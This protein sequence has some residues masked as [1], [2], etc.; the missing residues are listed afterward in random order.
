MIKLK[1]INSFSIIKSKTNSLFNLSK[2]KL[3]SEKKVK[4]NTPVELRILTPNSISIKNRTFF[5]LNKTDKKS[6]SK[7]SLTPTKKITI[8][9]I[10]NEKTEKRPKSRFGISPLKKFQKRNSQ[11]FVKYVQDYPKTFY[12][13]IYNNIEKMKIK[14]DR[15]IKVMRRNLRLTN[16]D[17]FLRATNLVNINTLINR[18]LKLKKESLKKKENKKNNTN[19]EQELSEEQNKK[20]EDYIDSNSKN[21]QY[22][23]RKIDNSLS[24]KKNLGLE[25]ISLK[26]F[27]NIKLK[28]F[29]IPLFK[30]LE[31]NNKYYKNMYHTRFSEMKDSTNTNE[32]SKKIYDAPY[33]LQKVNIFLKQPEVQL[34]SIYNKLK[35]LLN[36]IQYFYN[37]FLIKREFRHAFINMENPVKAHFNMIIEEVCIL[38]VKL[39][40]LILKEFYFSLS[41]LLFINIPQ[42]NEEME[43]TP[44]NEI[45]CLKYNIHFFQKVKDYYSA[46]VD[47]YNVIQKQIAEFKF[48]PNEFTALNNILDLARYNSTNLIS[49]A[50]TQIEKTKNDDDI[51]N[52]FEIGLNIKKKK[53][54]EKESGFERFH[55]RRKMKLLDDKEKINRIKSALNIGTKDLHNQFIVKLNNKENENQSILNSYLIKDMMNYFTP[56]IKQ[57]IISQQ[58]IERFKKLELERLKFD[59]DNR[60]MNDGSSINIEE[61]EN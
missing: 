57:K 49:M 58:V 15:T 4:F 3:K 10:E 34:K 8:K 30:S 25:K 19:I 29:Y 47:I 60:R 35:L 17:V 28:P 26:P 36:N 22:N 38:V 24:E 31:N 16:H 37:N 12:Q 5:N 43:K 6:K 13:K 11:S 9:S 46:C 18:G 59:P 39:I 14:A 50:N 27:Y 21:Q 42:I 7:P 44:S 45:E 61:N 53:Y 2:N 56:E 23:K 55:K 1:K 51:F 54:Y 33:I 20:N 41:Q 40:P 48:S 52:N 32:V